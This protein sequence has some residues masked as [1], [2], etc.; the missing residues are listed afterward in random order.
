MVMSI[1]G[2][3]SLVEWKEEG[4]PL[5]DN[6][7]VDVK[8]FISKNSELARAGKI[9][10]KDISK[11]G[12]LVA[13]L[14]IEIR[15]S[16]FL[17]QER[18]D[19]AMEMLRDRKYLLRVQ[20]TLESDIARDFHTRLLVFAVG[21][22]A[23]TG[24]PLNLFLK[25]PSSTGKTHLVVNISK[26]FPEEDVLSLGGLSPT[27]IIHDQGRIETRNN[28]KVYVVNLSKKLLVF[29]ESPSRETL[30]MLK[31]ILSHDK[32]EIE[33]KITDR[34]K[35]AKLATKNVIIRGWPATIFCTTETKR[36][37]EISTR[38]LLATPEISKEKIDGAIDLFASKKMNPWLEKFKN[39][40]GLRDSIVILKDNI[41]MVSIPYLRE[42]A[43][44]YQEKYLCNPRIMRDFQKISSLIEIIAN[45]H[46]FQRPIMDV[47]DDKYILAVPMDFVAANEIYR[48]IREATEEGI[49]SHVMR[50]Y[51]DIV[52]PL[53]EMSK[54]DVNS[55]V[56]IPNLVKTYQKVYMENV[57]EDTVRLRRINP[58]ISAGWIATVPDPSDKRRKVYE[59][60]RIEKNGKKIPKKISNKKIQGKITEHT[61][62]E[63]R[64]RTENGDSEQEIGVANRKQEIPNTY[65]TNS[66][67]E[68]C[69]VFPAIF[70]R[71]SLQ[72]ALFGLEKK[73]RTGSVKISKV[74]NSEENQTTTT[75]NIIKEY[76]RIYEEETTDNYLFNFF[77]FGIFLKSGEVS[78]TSEKTPDAPDYRTEKLFANCSLL[79]ENVEK[80]LKEEMKKDAENKLPLKDVI[81]KKLQDDGRTDHTKF[82]SEM[83]KE[84]KVP[85]SRIESTINGLLQEGIL[86]SPRDGL[87]ETV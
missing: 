81:L 41:K 55:S 33:Y 19:K 1:R 77:L 70:G 60:I 71:F 63:K 73:Y 17:T 64:K 52:C 15:K 9:S 85:E 26:Y 86:W 29:L 61:E 79:S 5:P 31:P 80:E 75:N 35:G 47:N 57:S 8:E 23:Y 54:N 38:S 56:S 2:L 83:S 32:M 4:E 59:P 48:S 69:S 82:V 28:K 12:N 25:G 30:N 21:M 24:I 68:I 6:W 20:K 66:E 65:R 78:L 58:L 51:Y 67:Q 18:Y 87:L 13:S 50:F 10:K 7:E 40:D 45:I 39:G 16:D 42:V 84:R 34:K 62:Q 49:P 14:E 53:H 72:N 74:T 43:K 3:K 27:A 46:S 11:L 37:E 44:T 22:S 76:E 36:L